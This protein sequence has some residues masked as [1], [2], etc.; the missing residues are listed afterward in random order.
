[1]RKPETNAT[2]EPGGDWNCT[3]RGLLAVIGAQALAARLAPA[4]EATPAPPEA[5]RAPSAPPKV[6]MRGRDV[7]PPRATLFPLSA[8]R[9]LDGPVRDAQEINRCYLLT[10]EPDRLLSWFR[11]EAGLDP[12]A[13]PYRGWESEAPLLP[14]H[15]LG[16]YLSGAS[17][18][19]QATGDRELRGRLEY[20]VDELDQ[21]QAAAGDGFALATP[22]GRAVFAEIARGKIEIGGLPWTGFEINGHFEPTYTLNKIMLGLYQ[23]LLTIGSPKARRVLVRLADWFGEAVLDHLTEA[24]TQTLLDCEHGSLHESFADVYRLTGDK[25]HLAWARRLCHER[26]LTPL[27]EGNGDFLTRYHANCQ[28]PK[29]TG[30]EAIARLTGEE[31]LDRAAVNFWEEV[32]GRRTWING[33]NSAGEHFFDHNEWEHA[34][35]EPAG[36]ETCNTVNMLRLTEVLFQA[37][38]SGRLM[39]YYERA[40][41]SHL[42]AAR[43]PERGMFVYF[44]NLRPG[45]YRVYSDPND[46]MWCCVGTGLESP[47]KYGQMI[48]TH[49]PDHS[50]LDVNLFIASVLQWNGKRVSVRQTTRFPDEEATTLSLTCARPHTWFRLRIRHPEWVADDA[51]HVTVNGKAVSAASARGDYLEIDRAWNTGDTVRVSLP[52]RTIA[53]PLPGSER[54]LALRHGPIVLAGALG[55]RGLSKED[56][57]RLD[58]MVA[59]DNIPEGSVPAFVVG[60]PAEAVGRLQP[61]PGRPLTFRAA[62]LVRPDDGATEDVELIPLFRCHFQRYSVYWRMLTPDALR[63]E[64]D[65]IAEVERQQR[66][67]DARTFDRVLIGDAA[68]ETAHRLQ[69]ERTEAGRGAYGERMETRWR[70]AGDGGWFGYDLAVPPERPA[71][72]LCTFWGRETGARTFDIIAADTTLATV[73]LG[74]TGTAGFYH[75]EFP[76]PI[77]LTRD[78]KTLTVSFKARP[79]NT[80]GGLFDLRILPGD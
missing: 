61:V 38:P 24:Q 69:G 19:V 57:W 11:R 51:L 42:L 45:A 16:F 55:R 30:F 18:M 73:T 23:A 7:T 32:V 59:R 25:K 46:S 22:G 4:S 56:F 14:G 1:M 78:R 36:P 37:H 13:P 28:I 71:I 50:A 8:I 39:D 20:I 9:L 77:E 31:R 54:Y 67:L 64:Q 47:G 6:A 80:A 17:M 5:Q 68:S 75:R 76:V 66:A 70:H 44:T 21:I 49:A 10:L 34:L 27:A 35:H 65:R 63:A 3:R 12:K 26:M 53:E 60:G 41:F 48:Y 74:D 62:G 72:L 40:L 79:G 29:Y 2:P 43:D 15:I 52:M 58:D 33:G